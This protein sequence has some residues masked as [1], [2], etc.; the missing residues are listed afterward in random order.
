MT[1]PTILPKSAR[2]LAEVSEERVRQDA[3]W[4]EQNHF[5]GTGHDPTGFIQVR[6]HIDPDDARTDCEASFSRGRGSWRHILT[7]EFAEAM[8]EADPGRLRAELIQV[9]AVAVAWV[10]AIDRRKEES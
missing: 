9:A 3:K 2:V 5:D 10:E 1:Y 6:H 7:E 4:G 8:A